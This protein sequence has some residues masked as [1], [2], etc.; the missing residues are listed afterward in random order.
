MSDHTPPLGWEPFLALCSKIHS[1]E[2]FDRIFDLFLTIEEKHLLASRIL[3][4]KELLEDK[5]TQREIAKTHHVSIAQIT[6]GSNAL[7]RMDFSVKNFL[8]TN[9]LS[10]WR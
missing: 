5:L 7:K 8:K 1:V 4:I 9:L 2:E 3:I 6:R 10:W